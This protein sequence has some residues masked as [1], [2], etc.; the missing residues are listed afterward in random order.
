MFPSFNVHK[1]ANCGKP[2]FWVIVNISIP[3]TFFPNKGKKILDISIRI[4]RH[5]LV[6]KIYGTFDYAKS[7]KL[8]ELLQGVRIRTYS[9]VL[10]NLAQVSSIDSSGLGVVRSLAH[11]VER[12]GGRIRVTN[13]P[14]H[15]RQMLELA[16]TPGL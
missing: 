15:L 7:L 11:Q 12:Q 10:F 2:N 3:F 8:K 1:S 16:R 5:T 14:R 9:N 6:I 13:T 4:L